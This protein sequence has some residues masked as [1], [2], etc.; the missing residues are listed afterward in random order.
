MA[1]GDTR[2]ASDAGM[3]V[4]AWQREAAAD[5]EGFWARAAHQLPW[6]RPWDR[7]FEWDPPTFRWFLGAQTNLSYNCLDR[8][9]AAGRGSQVALIA[10]NE[11]GERRQYTYAQ[12]LDAVTQLAAALRGLGIRKGDRIAI[13][14]PTCPEAIA[15]MLAA[16]R[17]G[18]IHLVVFAGFGAGALA[19]RI[20]LAGAKA[21]FV[22]D[23]TWRKGSEVQLQRIAEAALESG[24][25]TVERMVVLRRSSAS[26]PSPSGRELDWDQFLALGNKI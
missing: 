16:V 18:A 13:Y 20:R 1:T 15:L 11:R 22:A 23:V 19:D 7:V 5:P 26:P 4:R 2:T 17:I 10:L 6:F 24:C 14:M 8:H 9:V 21:L 25:P 12:L 3:L